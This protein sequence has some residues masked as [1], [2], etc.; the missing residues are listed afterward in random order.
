MNNI[1]G[2]KKDKNSDTDDVESVEPVEKEY[3]YQAASPDDLALVN[4]AKYSGYE[5]LG[6]DA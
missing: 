6:S 4:F 3:E 1:R 2:S 5:Y